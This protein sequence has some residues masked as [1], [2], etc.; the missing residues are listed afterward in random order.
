MIV[1]NLACERDHLFEGWFGS[2]DDFDLQAKEG[3]ICCPI[4]GSAAIAR[5]L[6]APYV[7]T[8][9][10][11]QPAQERQSVAVANSAQMFRKM[12][13][14]YVIKNTEDVGHRF[15]NEARKMHYKE[16]ADRAIRGRASDKEVA[17]LKEEGIDV[18]PI[19]G[20]PALPDKLH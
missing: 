4:C 11:P 13:V 9:S 18:L 12:F 15:P 17:E 5:Q 2:A 8:G 14:D 7:N 6:S 10:I 1:L 3:A 20:M 16:I 19:P